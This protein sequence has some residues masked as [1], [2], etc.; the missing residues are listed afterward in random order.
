MATKR[1]HDHVGGNGKRGW[2]GW[3]FFSARDIQGKLTCLVVLANG[4]QCGAKLKYCNTTQNF[5][6]HLSSVHPAIA[7]DLEEKDLPRSP[8]PR[9]ADQSQ[10][11]DFFDP[12]KMAE[13]KKA[14]DDYIKKLEVSVVR[15][16]AG[17]NRPFSAVEGQSHSLVLVISSL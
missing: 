12:R 2:P 9:L 4:Q 3:R 13:Q 1:Q 6:K 7:K 17:D 15:F 16:I 14:S 11:T 8:G 10:L 5:K